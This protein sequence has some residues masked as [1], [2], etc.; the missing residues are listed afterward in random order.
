ME[1]IR[2]TF[3][4]PSAPALPGFVADHGRDLGPPQNGLQFGWVNGTRR[5]VHEK[6]DNDNNSLNC[7]AQLYRD[8]KWQIALENGLYQV[9]VCT[10]SPQDDQGVIPLLVEGTP[11]FEKMRTGKNVFLKQ[12]KTLKVEDGQLTLEID[13]A[14]LP[15][16]WAQRNRFLCVPFLEIAPVSNPAEEKTLVWS[17]DS[18]A[19]IDRQFYCSVPEIR[20]AGRPEGDLLHTLWYK[21]PAKIWE[22]GVPLGNGRLGAVVYGNPVKEMIQFNEDTLWNGAPGLPFANPEGKKQIDEARK[23]IFANRPEKEVWDYIFKNVFQRADGKYGPFMFDY[24]NGG[25]L[26]LTFPDQPIEDYC[27]EL[28]LADGISVTRYSRNGVHFRQEVF[29]SADS[30]VVV[31]RL[32]ADKPG[33]ITLQAAATDEYGATISTEGNDTL[34]VNGR[35]P[36]KKG[37]SSVIRYQRRMTFLPEGGTVSATDK[38]IQSEKCDALTILVSIR[39]NFLNYRDVNGDPEQRA[40]AE[41]EAARKR[42]YNDLRTAH[43]ADHRRLQDRM[44]M[45]LGKAKTLDLPTDERIRRFR[46]S[47]DPQMVS[48]VFQFARYLMMGC[49]RP[50][51]QAANLQGIWNPWTAGAWGGKYTV[52]I[53][54]EMNYWLPDP[55]NLAECNE[56]LFDL[57][58]ELSDTGRETAQAYYGARGWVC[59][60]NTDVWRYNHP[61][62]GQA[63]MWPM[64]SAWLCDHLWEHYQYSL[65]R[66]FLEKSYPVLRDAALFYVDSLVEDPR[67][68]FLV[69]APSMSPENGGM[70]AAPTMD[71]QLM[72]SLFSRTIQAAQILER[73]PALQK[74]LQAVA[75]RLPPMM[76]GNWGQLREWTDADIDNPKDHHRHVSHLYALHPGDQIDYRRTPE[77]FQAAKVSLL[78][79]GDEATGWSLGWKTN[80]WA[81]LRDGEHAY[82]ILKLLIKP[83]YQEETHAWGSGLY[84]NF[85]DAHPP[86][87]IDGNFGVAAGILEMLL[88]SQ[89]GELDLLP[90][91]PSAWPTGAVTGMRARGALTVDLKW[92]GG[93]LAEVR[94]TPDYDGK[95]RVRLGDLVREFEGKAGR[96]QTLDGGLK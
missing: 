88:Q 67:S 39:T 22:Q 10:G 30:Q 23:M 90:A 62:D 45:D 94:I 79:R 17:V 43:V 72:N 3:R 9:S 42:T 37:I 63:G 2:I 31:I 64:A 73:D 82:E 68:G 16:D 54:I 85:L 78:A 75:K 15:N 58:R 44:S 49:S 19:E 13:A 84:P 89:N 96:A 4:P 24:L 65:D 6:K 91:L 74:Q 66:K 18:A 77:L 47:N 87:Q 57:I 81:R 25:E 8:A 20:S 80:F 48:L 32:A 21:S 52:N 55:A 5:G 29:T 28:N 61:I 26:L 71:V 60:H 27:R 38:T 34:V 70:H 12:T 11:Y 46:E 59:H 56:P 35:A 53:N 69:T 50:G 51:T 41:I 76:I 86:F 7:L 83:S 92:N 93:K 1:Q 40:R 95:V 36:D 14:R 33:S